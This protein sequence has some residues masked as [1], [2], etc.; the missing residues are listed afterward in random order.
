MSAIRC[1]ARGSV[2]HLD[3]TCPHVANGACTECLAPLMAGFLRQSVDMAS[4]RGDGDAVKQAARRLIAAEL[5]YSRNPAAKG[6][7]EKVHEAFLR[8]HA[9]TVRERHRKPRRGREAR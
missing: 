2:L 4:L 7:V 1:E 9:A 8:L 6:R 3:V 5:W